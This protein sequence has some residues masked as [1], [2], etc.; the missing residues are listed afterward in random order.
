MFRLLLRI[1]VQ[2]H[3]LIVILKIKYFTIMGIAQAEYEFLMQQDKEFEDLIHPIQLG[4]APLQWTKK[5]NST[6]TKE[7][8][9]FDFYRGSVELSKYTFN[10]RY[11]QTVILLRYDNGGRHTNPDGVL[12]EGPHVHLYRE[13]YNDKFAFQV[14]EVGINTSD[15]ME[16]VLK[17]IMQFCNIKRFP[18]IEISMF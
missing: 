15:S 2:I 14:S 6:K 11:R 4:P 18:S 9:L 16:E 10:K 1:L 8:F 12:F 13:G 5:I 7:V 17:K 3:T